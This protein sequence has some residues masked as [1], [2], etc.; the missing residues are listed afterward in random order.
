MLPRDRLWPE[1]DRFFSELPP[2]LFRDAKLLQ[3]DLALRYSRTGSFSDVLVPPD[4]FPLLE[5]GPW[6]LDDL[7]VPTGVERAEI[8]RHVLFAAVLSLAALQIAEDVADPTS[9]RDR[10]HVPLARFLW[11]SASEH[12]AAVAGSCPRFW[13]HREAVTRS[14]PDKQALYQL[15][16][17][18]RFRRL[19]QQFRQHGD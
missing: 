12:L 2:Y 16:Y 19:W 1:I 11:T 6:I 8:E 10:A 15:L 5:L 7:G 14:F 3:H 18:S 9:F 4:R 17:E 13:S